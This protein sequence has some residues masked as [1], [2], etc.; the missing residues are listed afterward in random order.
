MY[1]KYITY[2]TI[3]NPATL[4]GGLPKVFSQHSPGPSWF[5]KELTRNSTKLASS[6]TA[7]QSANSA[8]L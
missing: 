4:I 2:I 3:N 7:A 1:N 5:F 8:F 6:W